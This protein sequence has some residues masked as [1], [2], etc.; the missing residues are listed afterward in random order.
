MVDKLNTFFTKNREQFLPLFCSAMNIERPVYNLSVDLSSCS[1]IHFS[2]NGKNTLYLNETWTGQYFS[3]M[4]I[5]L[6]VTDK[7]TY[8]FQGWYAGNTLLTEEKELTVQISG[9]T[10]VQPR[11][12][13]MGRLFEV[14]E[15][16]T[17]VM[18][19]ETARLS[20]NVSK[21][22]PTAYADEGLALNAG[23]SL[24]ISSDK[25]WAAGAGATL[26]WNA[27]GCTNMRLFILASVSG[28]SPSRWKVQCSADG[29]TWNDIADFRA[30]D[31]DDP[32][33]LDILLP[34]TLNETEK[35]RVHIVSDK[36]GSAGALTLAQ[37]ILCGEVEGQ[38]EISE[39]CPANNKSY[40]AENS[41]S[42]DWIEL[43]N[44]GTTPL[45]LDGWYLSND[46]DEPYMF[47]LAGRTIQAQEYLILQADEEELPFK[48]SSS[49][50]QMLLTNGD[51]RQIVDVP[52]LADDQTYS[53]QWNGEWHVT[54]ATPKDA[55]AAGEIYVEPPF[56]APPK[57]SHAAGFFDAPFELTLTGFGDTR[58]FYT[59]DGSI[60][61][62]NA[63]PYTGPITVQDRSDEP[64]VWS[65]RQDVT[66][67]HLAAALPSSL[68][69]KCTTIRA[70][71]VDPNG[72]QST[73]V[74][75]TYF[76]NL[77]YENICVLSIVAEPDKLFDEDDGIYVVGKV[78]RD[79]LA[80]STQDH[81]ILDI[82]KPTNFS[83]QTTVSSK[84]KEIPATLQLFDASGN[85]KLNQELAIRIQG[86]YSRLRSQKSFKVTAR[87]EISG[88][89]K[90]DYALW[91]D[92]PKLKRF[93]VR[94]D[95]NLNAMPSA[96]VFAHM[97]VSDQGLVCSRATPTI[98]FLEG[99]FWGL[100]G[101]RPDMDENYIAASVGIPKEELI[102]I[103]NNKFLT[104]Q[105]Y[106]TEYRHWRAFITELQSLDCSKQSDY[107]YLCS[108][109]DVDS[110]IRFMAANLY[111]QN[112][113]A[114]GK[115]LNMTVWRTIDG[116]G[117]GFRDGKWRWTFQDMD[118]T[119]TT[120]KDIFQEFL[121]NE[122][123]FQLLWKNADFQTRF[124]DALTDF[125]S[126]DCSEG[127]IQQYLELFRS[128]Y[129]PYIQMEQIRFNTGFNMTTE[130]MIKRL[131][132]FFDSSRDS[133]LPDFITAMRTDN[134]ILQ[135]KVDLSDLS[136]VELTVNGRQALYLYDTWTGQYF[137]DR[138]LTLS[139]S[140]VPSY[141][142]LGWYEG[143]TL[144]TEDYT[145]SLTL[146]K[147]KTVA[148]RYTALPRLVDS[149]TKTKAVL[150]RNQAT[151]PS[152]DYQIKA[153]L[154]AD[155]SLTLEGDHALTLTSEDKWTADTGFTLQWNTNKYANQT[156]FT[157][158]SITD[159][160]PAKWT[161]Y[162]ST[163]GS[164][165][166]KLAQ[167]KAKEDETAQWEISLP[168]ELDDVNAVYLRFT[169]DKK[170]D[171]GSLTLESL[172]LCAEMQQ[173]TLAN[174]KEYA[175]RCQAIAGDSFIALDLEALMQ[176]SKVQISDE[177]AALR[178]KLTQLLLEQNTSTVAQALP[179]VKYLTYYGGNPAYTVT[180]EIV[181]L[182]HKEW[183]NAG[184]VPDGTA[185]MCRFEDGRLT[186]QTE[187]QVVDGRVQL[188]LEIG[189]YALLEKRPDQI[190]IQA[191]VWES[192]LSQEFVDEAL[193]GI[194]PLDSYQMEV[195]IAR[196]D[197]TAIHMDSMPDGMAYGEL[198]VYF[199]TQDGA[200]D[201]ALELT[202]VAAVNSDGSCDIPCGGVGSYLILRES[203]E[204]H[205]DYAEMI[206][207][208][209]QQGY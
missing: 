57:F 197:L 136:G 181:A 20:S 45:S 50:A 207:T 22:I 61:D 187:C 144:L 153:L 76:V 167:L 82:Q 209:R 30:S 177:E 137:R 84:E 118:C 205:L 72:N 11:Y 75:N 168:S 102:V 186:S 194:R 176:L 109:I 165:W 39:I 55:N 2:V 31:K 204:D 66:F 28:D 146:T 96:D 68:V 149:T 148:P 154:I 83:K 63:I 193:G 36:K 116:G 69:K 77:T 130:K 113:D 158:V 71:A 6:S 173:N 111:L 141:Q 147:D 171:G 119:C 206:S 93:L 127:R 120:E 18:D 40:K 200:Q 44:T 131:Q 88:S 47:S 42:P 65:M 52:P 58:V 89:N 164:E 182:S 34:D 14:S 51:M 85:L 15:K 110:Y 163:D 53:L 21:I 5:T 9:D 124:C 12:L 74:T 128:M 142:F 166:V 134:S 78:Y 133:F 38:L 97:L 17:A 26:A 178:N 201:G 199:I 105:E 203:L 19:G 140:Y 196:P 170:A 112:Y 150:A 185:Y 125:I 202:G 59:T 152:N 33:Q 70:V 179:D 192:E 103:K 13:A 49:G 81:T 4:S 98:V 1:D 24:E 172:V 29:E 60:P 25:K 10:A 123:L 139:A 67:S 43:Y 156:L 106:F 86:N 79:W 195:T 32:V 198:Y 91:S 117:E 16:K 23:E 114:I 191:R 138:Q 35:A 132:S 104:G 62:E 169:S 157:A 8:I 7:P 189:V 174:I 56:V 143:D 108:L 73:V 160:V 190:G 188:D 129:G 161:A 101:L 80:D 99:E 41:A 37:V 100:Y 135:L 183:V 3:D 155:D 87:K 122:I 208:R 48:L 159:G 92:L 151:L 162:W 121:P 175:A 64:N 180:N 107:D 94:N 184:I 115:V 95:G 145:L 126:I 46:P 27:D 90:V 54:E